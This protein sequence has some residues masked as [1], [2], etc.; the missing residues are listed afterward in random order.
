MLTSR[1]ELTYF[2]HLACRVGW[3]DFALIGTCYTRD[4]KTTLY[5]ILPK[6]NQGEPSLP[7]GSEA[8]PGTSSAEASGTFIC[9]SVPGYLLFAFLTVLCGKV[10]FHPGWGRQESRPRSAGWKSWCRLPDSHTMP[11][12]RA[13]NLQ[14]CQRSHTALGKFSDFDPLLHSLSLEGGLN[15]SV[16]EFIRFIS[17]SNWILL[18][19]FRKAKC[20]LISGN[21]KN[22]LCLWVCVALLWELRFKESF[23]RRLSQSLQNAPRPSSTQGRRQSNILAGQRSS[24]GTRAPQACFGQNY[25]RVWPSVTI[26]SSVFA[27]HVATWQYSV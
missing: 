16:C 23:T 10:I 3:W 22:V 9:P 4:S 15:C 6:F 17:C 5:L 21:R 26:L 1:S 13:E 2:L 27:L 7:R 14:E 18:L 19:Y 25:F 8:K 20:L 11:G 24:H 12:I